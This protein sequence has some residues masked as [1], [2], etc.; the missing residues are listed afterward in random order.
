MVITVCPHGSQHRSSAPLVCMGCPTSSTTQ[1]DHAA[2]QHSST[3]LLDN[4]ARQRSSTAQLD[5]TARPAMLCPRQAWLR[6]LVRE[7]G[8]A[9]TSERAQWLRARPTG[10]TV[11][12]RLEQVADGQRPRRPWLAPPHC[13]VSNVSV[14]CLVSSVT[15]A[16]AAS[17]SV[18]RKSRRRLQALVSSVKQALASSVSVKRSCL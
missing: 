9:C 15:Q 4:P 14:K 12:H 2:R 5:R 1:L 3:A 11:R 6:A 10:C 8:S 13:L 16:L 17:V 7:P 18:K